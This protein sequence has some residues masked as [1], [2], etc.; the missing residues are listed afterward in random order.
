MLGLLL[1]WSPVALGQTSR[2]PGQSDPIS[3]DKGSPG[4]ED[5]RT[6]GS[7]E[8]EMR[9]KRAIKFAEKEHL[10][11]LDRAREVAKIG[12]QIKAAFGVRQALDRED[13]KKLE[14][15]EKLTKR[16][17]S[18]AGGCEDEVKMEKPPENL[19]TAVERIAE[20]SAS[21]ADKVQKTPRQVVSTVVIDEA[22]VLLELIRI[23]RNLSHQG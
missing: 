7:I 18:E 2:P 8:D 1:L 20:V 21:L 23:L 19:T 12:E 16:L 4:S 13:A 6:L 15:L 5:G 9:A 10:E 11:N 14:R 22:N 17:R 3:A